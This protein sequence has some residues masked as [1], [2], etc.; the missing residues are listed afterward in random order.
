MKQMIET[1][2]LDN[3]TFVST[4]QDNQTL[5]MDS[6]TEK[7]GDKVG[8]SP[9]EVVL[10]GL[11]ACAGIDVKLILSKAKQDFKDIQVKVS[12][13]RRE[14]IPRIYTDINLHFEITGHD[15][16]E[17]QVAR[18]IK[19]SAEKYCSVSHMLQATVNITHSYEL[20][21]QA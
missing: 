13:N 10:M 8:P 18:A 17:K 5:V 3:Y 12:A 1:R 20:K 21:Q 19:L 16:S 11:S 2:W 4:N 6:P 14:E 9:M 7:H 15:L